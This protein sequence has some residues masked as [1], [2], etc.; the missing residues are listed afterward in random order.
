MPNWC[1]N[2]MQVKGPAQDIADIVAKM[3]ESSR[4]HPDGRENLAIGLLET[5]VPIGEW[6]Y[7]K[8]V[9]AWGT[10]WDVETYIPDIVEAEDGESLI[11]INFQSAW[12]P[13]CE[14]LLQWSN[15]YPSCQFRI[16]YS[17]HGCC[18]WGVDIMQDGQ[19]T[20]SQGGEIPDFVIE[21]DPDHDAAWDKAE[22]FLLLV[23]QWGEFT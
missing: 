7:D 22:E 9:K 13:P 8:A 5:F 18:F 4:V 11:G 19:V 10:K 15:S 17:E 21:D 16:A 1:D 14:A 2:D 6:D 20:D 23:K 12:S 3:E